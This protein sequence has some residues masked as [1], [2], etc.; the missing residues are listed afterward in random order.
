MDI[1][2]LSFNIYLA[3]IPS[4]ILLIYVYQKDIV[5]KE[6]LKLLVTLFFLGILIS[7]PVTFLGQFVMSATGLNVPNSNIAP[8]NYFDSFVLAFLVAGLIEEGYKYIVVLFATWKNK[9]FNH[10]YDA[11][12]YCVF[13]SLGFATIENILYILRNDFKVA[14][15]R[16]IIS[17]P[18][19]AF[20]AVACGFFLG[21]A[22]E[23]SIKKKT[24]MKYLFLVLSFVIPWMLHGL[25]DFLLYTENSIL[26]GVFSSFVAILY[27]VSYIEIKKTY[28]GKLIK[29]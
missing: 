3:V 27:I 11:I 25:F 29:K 17:V 12:V 8:I 16:A 10:K 4:V 13:V 14:I 23:S 2:L 15:Y 18:A 9:N 22:K 21:F 26:F 6:P 24:K 7:V 20:Y 1:S 19:H 5:E 28:D